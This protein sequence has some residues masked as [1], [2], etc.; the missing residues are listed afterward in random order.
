[1]AKNKPL[2]IFGMLALLE[3][4]ASAQTQQ[5]VPQAPFPIVPIQ[6]LGPQAVHP[7]LQISAEQ[8]K[9]MTP[10][11]Q[12]EWRRQHPQFMGEYEKIMEQYTPK[13]QEEAEAWAKALREARRSKP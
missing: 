12:A 9:A 13:T 2:I 6:Q 4:A 1:M 10:E 3:Q 8:W 5:A 11:Q 7:A